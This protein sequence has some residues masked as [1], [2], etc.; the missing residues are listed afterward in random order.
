MRQQPGLMAMS[1]DAGRRFLESAAM[2]NRLDARILNAVQ[3]GPFWR[4]WVERFI[5]TSQ[6]HHDVDAREI[7][8][9]SAPGYG[10][11]L[12]FLVSAAI[13]LTSSAN[14][15]VAKSGR[16]QDLT[17]PAFMLSALPGFSKGCALWHGGYPRRM[18]EESFSPVLTTDGSGRCVDT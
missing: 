1:K 6:M 18:D 5:V 12:G 11:G 2:A 13:S 10:G 15:G 14:L 8:S 4:C 3:A 7:W 9:P 16:S 17:L